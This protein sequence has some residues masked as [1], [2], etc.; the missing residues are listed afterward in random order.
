MNKIIILD[1]VFD[2]ETVEVFSNIELVEGI[3]WH[4]IEEESPYLK[5]IEV[6]KQFVDLS[7]C[8]GYEVWCNKNKL[9]KKHQ[10][11]NEFLGAKGIL[12]FPLIGCVYYPIV[13]NVSG[14]EFCCEDV[15][16]TP[17]TNR[18]VLFTGNLWHGVNSDKNESDLT[19]DQG[20]YYKL[21][22]KSTRVALSLNP[23]P[24]KPPTY[25]EYLKSKTSPNKQQYRC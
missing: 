5:I 13:E 7:D 25:A 6:I 18:M 11:R 10:D 22:D 23:W 9:P 2:D 14:S 12:D 19:S 24:Y 3:V 1:N 17:K 16:V 4:T 15:I 8:A 20:L 21:S